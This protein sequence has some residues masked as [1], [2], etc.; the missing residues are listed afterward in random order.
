MR[1]VTWRMRFIIALDV[2][3]LLTMI[4]IWL[5]VLDHHDS[6]SIKIWF[7]FL[8]L[9][10]IVAV[11]FDI[12]LRRDLWEEDDSSTRSMLQCVLKRARAGVRLAKFSI[13]YMVTFFISVS[14]WLAYVYFYEP[15]L[16]DKQY[17][18]LGISLGYLITF[19]V[20][21]ASVWY[22]KKKQREVVN[23]EATL[24]QYE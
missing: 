19:I 24:K 14:T 9:L 15:T 2:I 6:I 10:A 20:A 21:M 13:A 3:A 8:F 11:Y 17:S 18:V 23:L 16:I 7:G 5:Y 4:P 1:W 12:Y 22:K